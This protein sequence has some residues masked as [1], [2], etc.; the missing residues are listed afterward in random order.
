MQVDD[1]DSFDRDVSSHDLSD[2]ERNHY[3]SKG[4]KRGAGASTK[5]SKIHK[6]AD[7]LFGDNKAQKN[8]F[9]ERTLSEVNNEQEKNA[10]FHHSMRDGL[11]ND[12]RNSP[13][14]QK[15]PEDLQMYNPAL[16]RRLFAKEASKI[17][18]APT[19]MGDHHYDVKEAS[20]NK[21]L[22]MATSANHRFQEFVPR[23]DTDDEANGG[24]NY[25]DDF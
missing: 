3:K 19:R 13:L 20:L 14:R 15:M 23:A 6:A 5:N 18:G 21:D 17:P 12:L 24:L 4:G 7:L 9:L 10:L 1:A 8:N 2:T 22:L 16:E 25:G 11:F